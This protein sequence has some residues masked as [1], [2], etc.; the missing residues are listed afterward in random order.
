MRLQ[1]KV[2]PD[3]DLSDFAKLVQATL[4]KLSLDNTQS[5]IVSGTTDGTADTQRIIAH[6]FQQIPSAVVVL[7]GNAY[8]Q[9]GGISNTSV[10]VRSM[11]QSQKFKL[12]VIL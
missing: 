3:K 6:G 9:V 2:Y 10:D 12:L 5:R 7:E 4:Q 1:Y 8:I 11:G